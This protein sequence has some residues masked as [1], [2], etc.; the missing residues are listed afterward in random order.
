MSDIF[1][2]CTPDHQIRA[3]L[4][5]VYETPR[6]THIFCTKNPRRYR[7]FGRW[8]DNCILLT[9]IT[10]QGDERQR[11]WDLLEAR[12]NIL[13]LSL[14]P[15]SYPIDLTRLCRP[16]FPYP[17][18]EFPAAFVLGS[19]LGDTPGNIFSPRLAKGKG[20]NLLIIG[21][22]SGRDAKKHRPDPAW[23][24]SLIDQARAAKV[25]VFVKG[26]LFKQFPIQEWPQ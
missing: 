25:P 1:H 14:E 24:Q 12:A 6:H 17:G 7:D 10:G 9:T 15:L 2:P 23:V 8:P 18:K 16:L 22:L 20:I 11:I 4:D 5:V 3:I 26:E 21:A 19:V 13:G